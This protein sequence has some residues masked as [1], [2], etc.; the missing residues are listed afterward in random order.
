MKTA[1]II[2]TLFLVIAILMT[3]ISV[4]LANVNPDDYRPK[5]L[6]ASEAGGALDIAKKITGVV[7]M[8]SGIIFVATILILGIKYMMGSLEERANYKKTMIPIVIGGIMIFGITSIL[9]IIM[10]M[11]PNG[12]LS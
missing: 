3:S 5:Y 6:I 10:N 12:S 2:V 9:R 4:V 7:S 8:V 11:M 1:K